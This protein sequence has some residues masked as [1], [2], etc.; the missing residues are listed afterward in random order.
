[1]KVQIIKKAAFAVVTSLLV[2]GGASASFAE[3]KISVDLPN[4]PVAG[5]EVVN[6]PFV[7]DGFTFAN[8][9]VTLSVEAGTLTVADPGS[10]V[11]LNAGYSSLAD[12][13]EISFHGTAAN[14]NTVMG[15]GTG[16]TWKAPGDAT[17][18]TDLK[19]RAQISEFLVGQSYDPAT[20]HSYK[21]VSNPLPWET[22]KDAAAAMTI[23]GKKGYLANITSA[24][25]NTF[26]ANKSGAS[27]VWFGA[28]D[29][30]RM[31]NFA[32]AAA[33]K[34]AIT[35]NPQPLGNYY[36]FGGTEG[37]TQFSTGL[38][39]PTG[40]AGAFTSWAT[41]EP[42]NG[43]PGEACAVTNWNGGKGEWND[44]DC[45]RTQSYLVEFDTTA[46]DFASEV[47][48][49]D[50]VT[51]DSVDAVPAPVEEEAPVVDDLANTGFDAA[52]LLALALALIAAGALVVV[53]ARKN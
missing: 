52:L 33:A 36:W 34:P 39:T 24:A 51:G 11:T 2:L 49:F 44:L 35:V 45:A 37:G 1:M 10:L 53:R 47:T 4:E 28:T 14:V 13:T 38:T 43:G 27:D 9:T 12:Q 8:I 42:N 31:V 29:D 20:G 6:V 23:M 22:A 40:V 16:V 25:E 50:N 3:S 26:V 48:L 19:L 46:A 41:G 5:G 7:L 17:T 32:L 18:P 30:L 21:F 15:M